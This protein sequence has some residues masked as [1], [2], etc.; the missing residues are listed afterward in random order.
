MKPGAQPNRRPG[1]GGAGK[2][3]RRW[4]QQAEERASMIPAGARSS[5]SRRSSPVKNASQDFHVLVRC[6][7]KGIGPEAHRIGQRLRRRLEPD[8]AGGEE[9]GCGG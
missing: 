5:A 6:A 8:E 3:P 1:S 7:D 2:R 9:F 4:F